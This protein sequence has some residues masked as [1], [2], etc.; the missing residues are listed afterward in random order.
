MTIGG[1]SAAIVLGAVIGV[2][3][4][5]IVPGRRSMPGW[6]MI[7]VGIVAA[8]AG[9]ALAHMFGLERQGW[10][11]WETVFQIVLAALGVYLVALFW[12]KPG[13]RGPAR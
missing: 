9:T 1:I 7:A 2:L 13:A 10:N 11:Y 3:G 5:L 8:I 4:R 12:P 6:L